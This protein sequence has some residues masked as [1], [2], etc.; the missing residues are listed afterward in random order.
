M[1][2]NNIKPSGGS[3]GATMTTMTPRVMVVMTPRL[4]RNLKKIFYQ[5]PKIHAQ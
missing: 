2:E 3:Q 1:N 4:P 5:S